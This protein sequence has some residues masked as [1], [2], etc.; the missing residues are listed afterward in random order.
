MDFHQSPRAMARVLVQY[1]ACDRRIQSEVMT[2]F[3]VRLDPSAIAEIRLRYLN[4]LKHDARHSRSVSDADAR[5]LR[6][7]N[8]SNRLFVAA[9]DQAKAA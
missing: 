5:L 2:D 4:S 3:G 9:L 8:K 7:M 6:D 1:I